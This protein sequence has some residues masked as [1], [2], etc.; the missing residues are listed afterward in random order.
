M[1]LYVPFVRALY[2]IYRLIYGPNNFEVFPL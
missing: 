1:Y 2:G